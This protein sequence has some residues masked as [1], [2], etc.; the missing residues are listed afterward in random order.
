M[1]SI[2]LQ[3]TDYVPSTD[4]MQLSADSLHAI[5]CGANGQQLQ[6]LCIASGADL[7][8][9]VP[10]GSPGFRIVAS[11]EV[12]LAVSVNLVKRIFVSLVRAAK[13]KKVL[14]PLTSAM[15]SP[16]LKKS[17]PPSTYHPLFAKSALLPLPC[18]FAEPV[19]LTEAECLAIIQSP[20]LKRVRSPNSDRASTVASEGSSFDAEI[21]DLLPGVA[22][23]RQSK[24]YKKLRR[25]ITEID[26]LKSLPEL[27]LGQKNK[28]LRRPELVEQI[29]QLLKSG[30]AAGQ[31]DRSGQFDQA[32]RADRSEQS[33]HQS[34]K[35]KQVQETDRAEQSE[36]SELYAKR[37]QSEQPQQR[38]EMELPMLPAQGKTSSAI[39]TRAKSV[40]SKPVL[41]SKSVPKKLISLPPP[42]KSSWPIIS[43]II[44]CL[45][46]LGQQKHY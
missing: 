21:A 20:Y 26:I 41:K 27:D 16:S 37:I 6:E 5:V 40:K 23:A 25:R 34:D 42:T 44:I 12:S 11:T 39:I 1:G 24:A 22:G 32:E 45:F 4:L 13:K 14:S 2:F 9:F 8:E 18:D 29:R 30:E 3:L 28:V 19:V 43:F 35:H 46:Y 31:A 38:Q 17:S 15:K 10:S 7:I 33:E 36:E